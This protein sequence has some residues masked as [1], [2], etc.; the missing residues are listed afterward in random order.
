MGRNFPRNYRQVRGGRSLVIPEGMALRVALAAAA[1]V[2]VVL[3][4]SS[5]TT[6]LAAAQPTIVSLTFDDGRATEYA[7][8]SLLAARGMK[9]TF[10]INSSKLGTD[11]DYMTWAQVDG[12]A[13]DGNEIGGHTAFHVD[14]TRTDST[15]AQREVCNDRV[16]LLNRGYQVRNFAYPFG[17]YNASAQTI[18]RNCGYNSARGVNQFIPPP[19]ETIPPQDPYA[20]R[21]AGAA[22]AGVS[23]ATLESYVTKVEQNGG[24][25]APLVFHQ[26][27]N[28]CDANAI[29]PTDLG[30]FLDW[31]QLR[32]GNG[33]VVKT[34]G[35]VIGGSVQ[36]AVAGPPP[37]PAP[38]GTNA[39]RNA[40]LEQQA[41]GNLAPDCWD[42]D[43]WG[44]NSYSW[45]RTTDAH[46][47][48][49][50]ERV[51]V[52]NYANG[53][54]KL[55]GRRD[56]GFCTPS[57]TPG[58]RYRLTAWYKSS[59]AV[60][61]TAFT[62]DSL[63]GFY[64]WT[65]G[66]SF[67]AS[68]TWAQASWVSPVIPSGANGISFGLTIASNGSLTVDDLG[69]DDAAS[70]GAG[71]TTSPTVAVT[72]PANGAI[73]SGSVTIAADASDDTAVDHVDYLVDGSL[74]GTQTSGPYS[75]SWDSHTVGNGTHTIAARAVDTA[76]NVA[77]SQ[78][79]M[80]TVSNSTTNLLQNASLETAS[81]GTPTCWLLG[82]FGTNTFTWTRTS[83]AHSGGFAETLDVTSLT[84][85]DRKLVSTQDSGACAPAVTAGDKYTVSV[86]YKSNVQARIFAYYRNSSGAWTFWGSASF[87]ASSSWARASWATPAVPSGAT[88]LSVAMGLSAVGSVTMDDFALSG[89]APA[90]PSDTIPPTTTITCNAPAVT[91]GCA[92]GWYAAPVDVTLS[93]TDTGGSDLKEIRYTTDGSDPTAT[94]G[95]VYSGPFLVTATTTVKYRAFDNAGNAET[96][97]SQLIL[98]DTTPPTTTIS[99]NGLTC[100]TGYYNAA[101]SATLSATDMG[102]SGLKEIRYTTDGSDP[103]AT[104]GTVYSGPFSV[105]ATTTVKY[106]AFDNLGYAETVKSQLIR[107]DV[108]AP[109]VAITAPINGATLTGS[110]K[111][112]ASASDVGGSGIAKVTFYL[113]GTL[114]ATGTQAP[115][116]TQWNTK[117]SG[118]GQ[119]RLTAIAQDNAGNTTTSSA[120]TV[121]VA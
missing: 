24:G 35:D 9:A 37:P 22:G 116:S 72:S 68:S 1:V 16:N 48:S 114:L 81:G 99:C 111:V 70:S 86:Y 27:C 15:E 92:T 57:V 50:A 23:L 29:S 20:I 108:V 120:V 12:L 112:T 31:L 59:A 58:H 25:W 14:L 84:D 11:S 46:T 93:A 40:S 97:K 115:Y 32:A 42:F 4:A 75:L 55:V 41:S 71:D 91:P 90:P 54:S 44:N 85:G 30:A 102:G 107:I 26:I 110:V 87:P 64:Y 83:D 119:H 43:S 106:R 53:D 96:V 38:N 118:K 67:P 88:H 17:A 104:S 33:T 80:A 79:V 21:V 18:V 82:G 73:A 56:L 61:F 76:G 78:A 5:R 103:T 28:A 45:T 98:I 101:V 49:Y 66:S 13:A 10:Y 3:P 69:L 100:A 113:D 121:T 7:A 74:V 60:A 19:A 34:L 62:R 51:D 65:T 94:S 39:L 89:D 95:T 117:K 77:T 36:P 6:A 2:I 109:T 47:G 63:G 105:A 8:R 52:S